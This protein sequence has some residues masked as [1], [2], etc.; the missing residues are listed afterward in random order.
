M[1]TVQLETL[2]SVRLRVVL[3]G[4]CSAAI[5]THVSGSAC[6][7]DAFL[8]EDKKQRSSW[9]RLTPLLRSGL[10]GVGSPP[11][12]D[13]LGNPALFSGALP[14]NTQLIFSAFESPSGGLLLCLFPSNC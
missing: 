12:P 1:V 14:L 3:A 13:R 11:P 4:R 8:K 6:L 10:H 5:M 9:L 2:V 7:K